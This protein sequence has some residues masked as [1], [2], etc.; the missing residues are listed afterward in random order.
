M[1]SI[2]L[3][4]NLAVITGASGMLGRV[5]ARTFADCGADLVLHYYRN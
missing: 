5:M 4:G 2:D 1:L 3:R